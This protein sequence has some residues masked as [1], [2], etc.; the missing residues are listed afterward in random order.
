MLEVQTGVYGQIA[1]VTEFKGF[2]ARSRLLQ[3]DLVL[4]EFI[5]LRYDGR[6]L[7]LKARDS[8]T[9]I[10]Q[11]SWTLKLLFASKEPRFINLITM[12]DR[13]LDFPS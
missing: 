6:G 5:L 4:E 3:Y 12:L 2:K 7:T 11:P 1:L 9:R 10:D 13:F 8:L